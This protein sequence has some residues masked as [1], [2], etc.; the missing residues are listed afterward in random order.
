MQFVNVT[1]LRFVELS[2]QSDG[3]GRFD[4]IKA[5]LQDN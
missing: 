1:R 3:T 4:G 5:Q 2:D